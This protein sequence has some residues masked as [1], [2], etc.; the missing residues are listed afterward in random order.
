M[1]EKMQIAQQVKIFCDKLCGVI[2]NYI[3]FSIFINPQIKT[4]QLSNIDLKRR[5]IRSVQY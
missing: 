4:N 1:D 2:I 3:T 5:Y